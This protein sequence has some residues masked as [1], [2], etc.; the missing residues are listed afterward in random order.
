MLNSIDFYTWGDSDCCLP[1]GATEATLA[2]T[3]RMLRPGD[4]LI[5]EEVRG[6]LTGQPE[7]ADPAH[8]CAVCLTSV[9]ITDDQGRPLTDPAV[10]DPATGQPKDHAHHL[11]RR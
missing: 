2:G 3:F 1:S 6:P 5:F 8:R 9:I 10:D 11:V 7:D 4:M